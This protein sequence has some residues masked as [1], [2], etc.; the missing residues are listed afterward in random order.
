M[1]V[2]VTTPAVVGDNQLT[3][4][5]DSEVSLSAYVCI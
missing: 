2:A 3:N 5:Y 4:L 1:P